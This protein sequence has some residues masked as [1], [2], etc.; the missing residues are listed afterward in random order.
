MGL[1][2]RE[3]DLFSK[4]EKDVAPSG[5]P[6]V[7][8]SIETKKKYDAEA[9]KV[10]DEVESVVLTVYFEAFGHS[11]VTIKIP[12]ENVVMATVEKLHARCEQEEEIPVRFEGLKIGLYHVEK[13]LGI[14]C[15]AKGFRELTE[16]ELEE[17]EMLG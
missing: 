13:D 8:L 11:T 16:K 2:K 9:K 6:G 7:L 4:K 17:E 10:L 5:K 3:L 12:I 14:T 15:T 1:K